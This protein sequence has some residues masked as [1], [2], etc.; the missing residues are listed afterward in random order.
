MKTFFSC[1]VA[2]VILSGALSLSGAEERS[3]EELALETRALLQSAVGDPDPASPCRLAGRLTFAQLMSAVYSGSRI[4]RLVAL[5]A[6]GCLDDPWPVL[7]YMAALMGARERPVASRASLILL[8]SL[9][10]VTG[11][12]Y[13][14]VVEGQVTQLAG[15]L[16]SL[17]RDERIDLDMR[18]SAL[19]GVQLLQTIGNTQKPFPLELLEDSDTVI[20]RAVFALLVPPIEDTVLIR[21]AKMV[22]EDDDLRLRGQAAALLC[23]NALVHGVRVPSADLTAVMASVLGN[24]EV[25]AGA[26]G[27]VLSCLSNFQTEARVDLIDL[28]MGHPDPSIKELWKTLNKR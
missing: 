12:P 14:E 27:A 23:E 2:T 3:L 22:E 26:V 19:V 24:Y 28:A 8:N 7:P 11:K 1:I 16:L 18:A 21:L 4:E 10:K 5:D 6:T 25:P 20:R 15:R 9:S 13:L 17:A